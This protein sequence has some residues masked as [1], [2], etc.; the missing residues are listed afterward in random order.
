MKLEKSFVFKGFRKDLEEKYGREKAGAIWQYANR[1]LQ[2]LEAAE[3]VA[4]KTSRSFVFP[5]VALFWSSV[6]VTLVTVK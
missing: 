6:F 2:K 3:P 5:V 1:E 4:D